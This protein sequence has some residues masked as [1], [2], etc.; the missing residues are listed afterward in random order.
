MPL[1]SANCLCK[2]G[3]FGELCE[4]NTDDC[5]SNPCK[6]KGKCTDGVDEYFC[7]CA[8]TGFSGPQC[9]VNIDEC[10]VSSPCERGLCNDTLGDYQCICQADYCGK[11]CSRRDPC[12]LDVSQEVILC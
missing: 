9:E 5:A 7:D 6:N 10:A 3:Y 8:G 4:N 12:Q 11:N 2:P 1:Q